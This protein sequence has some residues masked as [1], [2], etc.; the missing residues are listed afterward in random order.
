VST[1]SLIMVFVPPRRHGFPT[2]GVYSHSES[3]HFD[4]PYFPHRDSRPTHS[5]GEVQSVL[6][7][8]SGHMVE[9]VFVLAFRHFFRLAFGRSKS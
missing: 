7:T 3:S 6:K 9:G 2:R 8:S 1:H 4:G 5:N